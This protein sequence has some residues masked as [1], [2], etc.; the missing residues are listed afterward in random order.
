[1]SDDRD[2]GD[3]KDIDPR[4]YYLHEW[5]AGR[6]GTNERLTE[7]LLA[8]VRAYGTLE[9]ACGCHKSATRLLCDFVGFVGAKGRAPGQQT[10]AVLDAKLRQMDREHPAGRGLE[11]KLHKLADE[12]NA[13]P[14]PDDK[15]SAKRPKTHTAHS[16]SNRVRR[17]RAEAKQYA[18]AE[19]ERAEAT[20]EWL[21]QVQKTYGSTAEND[22]SWVPH[23]GPEFDN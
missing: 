16:L 18:Q 22:R 5:A 3:W 2:D 15:H 21:N 19:Q 20:Q 14:K 1:M 9:E 4:E 12:L 8:F 7:A 6:G 17:L 13:G 10:D 23:S 11:A